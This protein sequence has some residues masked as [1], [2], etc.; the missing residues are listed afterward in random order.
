MYITE[1]QVRREFWF[2]E[3]SHAALMTNQVPGRLGCKLT[4]PFKL[5]HGSKPDSKMWFKLFIIGYWKH[6]KDNSESRSKI[7]DQ[8]LD[9]I[10]VGC[11]DEI[12]TIHF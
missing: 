12:N 1:K 2:Y 11:N 9:G 8:T 3:I 5:V 6:N 10:V 4:S 7:E